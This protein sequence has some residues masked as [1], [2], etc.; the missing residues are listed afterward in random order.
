MLRNVLSGEVVDNSRLSITEQ[1]CYSSIIAGIK[2]LRDIQTWPRPDA[3]RR[4][5]VGFD[6]YRDDLKDIQE[7]NDLIQHLA[8]DKDLESIYSRQSGRSWSGALY[9]FW[10]L[11]LLRILPETEG[12]E[13]DKRIFQKWFRR[14]V[15]ELYSPV[16]VWRTVDTITGLNLLGKELN[17]DQATALISKPAYGLASKVWGPHQYPL[18]GQL[19]PNNWSAVGPEGYHNYNGSDSKV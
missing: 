5:R 7:V 1:L 19:I 10:E 2:R 8:S 16:A 4:L 15:S 6:F 14:F 3:A 17:F 13:P 11:L 9:K 18:E 12:M